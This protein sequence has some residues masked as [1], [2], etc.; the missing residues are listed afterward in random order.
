[1]TC[2]RAAV[3]THP[4]IVLSPHFSYIVCSATLRHQRDDFLGAA[5]AYAIW[6]RSHK[7]LF[8]TYPTQ[9]SAGHPPEFAPKWEAAIKQVREDTSPFFFTGQ[10]GDVILTHRHLAHSG[11]K[12]FSSQIRQAVFYDYIRQDVYDRLPTTKPEHP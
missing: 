6:P 4:L 2:R 1:M 10:A 12:N 8:Y 7:R 11:T 3:R 5:G 9:F